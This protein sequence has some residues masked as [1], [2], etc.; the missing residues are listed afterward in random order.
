[1]AEEMAS[2]LGHSHVAIFAD[3]LLS[4][5]R[6]HVGCDRLDRRGWCTGRGGPRRRSPRL[7]DILGRR[8]SARPT[9]TT[10]SVRPLPRPAARNV[11]PGQQSRRGVRRS[12]RSLEH[13]GDAGP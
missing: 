4:Q 3:R 1:V 12:R 6:P 2:D 10:R 13:G 7:R 9:E 8:P 11:T 5:L